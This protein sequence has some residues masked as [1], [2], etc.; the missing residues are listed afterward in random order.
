[1]KNADNFHCKRKPSH[2]T[3]KP[4]PFT[5]GKDERRT[6]EEVQHDFSAIE[7]NYILCIIEINTETSYGYLSHLITQLIFSCLSS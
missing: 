2:A 4:T 3:N 5:V 1:M 6:P 7:K